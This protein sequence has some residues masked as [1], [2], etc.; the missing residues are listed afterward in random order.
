MQSSLG[1]ATITYQSLSPK[2]WYL[3][4]SLRLLSHQSGSV[5]VVVSVNLLA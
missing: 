4:N 3:Y 5:A 1:H 2:C